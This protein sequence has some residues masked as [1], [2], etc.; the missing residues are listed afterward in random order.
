MTPQKELMFSKKFKKRKEIGFIHFPGF[1]C[2]KYFAI[3]DIIPVTSHKTGE[4]DFI[5]MGTELNF[6]YSGANLTE[7]SKLSG[8]T[9]EPSFFEGNL[10][11]EIVRLIHL[12]VRPILIIG[13]TAGNV[14]TLYIT[15]RPSLKNVS[16]CFYMFLLALADTSRR[17]FLLYL[18]L[19]VQMLTESLPGTF[20]C[21]D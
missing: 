19:R 14:L 20:K 2:K 13:G 12:I 7:L 10:S 18:T 21:S 16:T 5:M 9:T 1:F 6:S 11:S 17:V 15:R 3:P 8:V 4:S